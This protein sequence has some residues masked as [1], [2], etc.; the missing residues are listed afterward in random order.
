MEVSSPQLTADLA[1]VQ[2]IGATVCTIRT[3]CSISKNIFFT[4]RMDMSLQNTYK[5]LL[6][7]AINFADVVTSITSQQIHF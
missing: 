3:I 2:K 1:F 5:L 7:T 6:Q 4:L